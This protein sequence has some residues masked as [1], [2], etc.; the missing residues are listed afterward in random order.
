[1][2]R[3]CSPSP[4]APSGLFQDSLN[5]PEF[6]PNILDMITFMTSAF[7]PFPHLHTCPGTTLSKKGSCICL[8]P[9]GKPSC[10]ILGVKKWLHPTCFSSLSP[11]DSKGMGTSAN[12]R[13]SLNFQLLVIA[14]TAGSAVQQTH[15]QD[16]VSS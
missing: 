13:D 15:Q 7:A 16:L 6:A 11:E 5:V 1:M 12:S 9:W 14:A 2:K 4:S 10:L 3:H 8:R